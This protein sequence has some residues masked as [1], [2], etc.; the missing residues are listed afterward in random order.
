MIA[1]LR[2]E[3]GQ[4]SAELMGM[5][6]WLVLVTVIVWQ[7]CLVAW[8]YTQVSNAAR[9]ASRVEG[10]G[11]DGEK[12]AKNALS[13]PLQK[14]I[15]KID[16]NGEKAVVKVKMPLL[17]PGLLD[18]DQLL[19][20]GRAE[21]PALMGLRDRIAGDPSLGRSNGDGDGDGVSY[22]RRRLLEEVNLSEIAEL[23]SAQRR[24]RLE[25][26]VGRMVSRE[27][28]VL[29]T[30]ERTRLIRRVIDEAIGLGVL[31]PLLA[32]PSVTEIMVNGP[33]EVYLERNGRL[34]KADITFTDESQLYQTIDRIVSQ[35]NRRV[36]ESSPMVDAR[37]P[38]GERVNVIIPPLALRG[39][40]MTI[41][42][43]PRLFTLDQLTEMNSI[44]P[45]TT[46][47]L[48]AVVEGKLNVV[49][50]GG[51]GAGKTTLLNAMSA[52]VP[53]GERIITVEDNAELRLQQPH[54]VTLEARPSNVEGKG[55][56]SIRDLV[57]NSLRMRP[58]RIIVGEVRGA[59]TLD[60][61]QALNTGHEG[62]L[63]TVHANSPRRRDPPPRDARDDERAPHP[64]R[65][66]AR[67]DQ[68]RDPRDRADRPLRRRQAP[69]RRGRDRR[70][71]APRDVPPRHGRALRGRPD[72]PRP[73]RHRALPPLPAPAGDPPPARC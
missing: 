71:D 46:Q 19:A 21:L 17:I 15:Q 3:S 58:D 48:R 45:P 25:R 64:V 51:T 23:S 4:A 67:P 18:S 5:I 7:I 6:W 60:M 14:T 34:E 54:V 69:H 2:D 8:T 44:D 12:A 35:V 62:S 26:V 41:R 13:K 57:R 40:T 65:G 61:L 1:R 16:V 32:D 11:G 52:A 24:A 50:S 31:E 73:P 66:P 33:D 29:S 38:T 42:R 53:P 30:A 9:T 37:L 27:G 43:F 59:E 70:L 20:T 39:P 22:Y 47:L 63:V 49:I 68:L 55:A 10:R 56:V 72:R 36:D 28:P